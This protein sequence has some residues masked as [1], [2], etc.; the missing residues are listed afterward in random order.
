MEEEEKEGGEGS[1]HD[2]PQPG[3]L[4]LGEASRD[5]SVVSQA[6]QVSPTKHWKSDKIF[7]QL[8]SAQLRHK[9]SQNLNKDK[10]RGGDGNDFQRYSCLGPWLPSLSALTEQL[11]VVTVLAAG[12]SLCLHLTSDHFCRAPTPDWRSESDIALNVTDNSSLVYLNGFMYVVN[13]ISYKNVKPTFLKLMIA[14][15]MSSNAAF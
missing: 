4:E 11:E 7:H 13:L 3:P 5:L 8:S 12:G 14:S 9:L 6:L 2:A 10:E 1:L 15:N